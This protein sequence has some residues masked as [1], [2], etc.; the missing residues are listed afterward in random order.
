M[1][2]VKDIGGQL[3]RF[4]FWILCGVVAVVGLGAWHMSK[5][6][7]HEEFTTNKGQIDTGYTSANT[8]TGTPN[9]PNPTVHQE[10]KFRIK[11]LQTNVAAV[12]QAQYE[13]Q[14]NTILTWPQELTPRFLRMVE[15]LRPIETT[16]PGPTE[17]AREI[18]PQ[19]LRAEYAN[20]IKEELPKLASIIHAEWTAKQAASSGFGGSGYDMGGSAAEYSMPDEGMNYGYGGSTR[21]EANPY[22]V[23][24]SQANQS[25]ILG[26]FTWPGAPTTLQIVYAQEDLW[27]LKN[28][29]EIINRTNDRTTERHKA[30]IKKIESIQIGRE[31][32]GR[33]GRI[34]PILASARG[35][36]GE[37]G[38]GMDGS[39]G[40][41]SAGMPDGMSGESG[42]GETMPGSGEIYGTGG[43]APIDPADMR[44]VDKDYK[45]L[46]AATVRS[47]VTTSPEQVYLAVAKRMPVRLVCTIDQRKIHKL[48]VECGNSPLTVEVRQVRIGGNAGKGAQGG[49]GGGYGGSSGFGSSFE[50]TAS[51]GSEGEYGSMGYGSTR[52]AVSQNN[53]VTVEIYGIVY[54]YNPVNEKA[55]GVDPSE[56][57]LDPGAL[58]AD[59]GGAKAPS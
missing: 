2:K 26:K 11:A 12:W 36:T 6:A 22:V 24:W 4:H 3:K 5:G 41:G 39:A 51:P 47:D 30:Y 50:S 53:D 54:I 43:G 1:D 10:M 46:P 16:V 28:I 17:Q 7:L 13:H 15:R 48:L 14:K 8:L 33:T 32:T 34:T 45:P 40:M 35:M 42:S 29:M 37:A 44:Y 21:R 31:A 18:L 9:P 49:Y 58:T 23:D 57:G 20:Y 27:V 55:L 52:S 56:G 38:Y 19:D 59:A 25:Q